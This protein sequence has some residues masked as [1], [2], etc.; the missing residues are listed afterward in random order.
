M[1]Q[2]ENVPKIILN[3]TISLFLETAISILVLS[4][5]NSF[6]VLFDKNCFVIFYLKKYNFLFQH[7]KWPAQGTSSVPI[8]SAHFRSLMGRRL[9]R[10]IRA[11]RVRH[12]LPSPSAI[13][14]PSVILE[15]KVP[16]ICSAALALPVLKHPG[17]DVARNL[18]WEFPFN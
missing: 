13:L 4:N 15:L 10:P 5:H 11:S 1:C 3:D 6:R 16:W 17:N 12:W 18:P 14:G 7:W 2:N 8:V 9:S